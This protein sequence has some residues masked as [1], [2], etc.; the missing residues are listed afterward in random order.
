MKFTPDEIWDSVRSQGA[1]D[2]LGHSKMSCVEALNATGYN[3]VYEPP[4]TDK[5]T[6]GVKEGF[7]AIVGDVAGPW[8]VIIKGTVS[9]PVTGE[10]LID[11]E[12]QSLGD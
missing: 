4:E 10:I 11:V 2:P 5:L 9:M 3:V 8:A 1:G 12:E 7:V 6:I